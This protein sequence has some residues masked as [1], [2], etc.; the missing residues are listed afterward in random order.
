MLYIF[1]EVTSPH[2]W[3][4]FY[5]IYFL[6]GDLPSQMILACLLCYILSRVVASPL[7]W[8]LGFLLCYLFFV[9]TS[10]LWIGLWIVVYVIYFL[11]GDLPS[12]IVFGLSFTVGCIFS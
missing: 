4:V 6:S 9:V 5:V 3:L 8:S 7:K 10:R 2:L 12:E 11:C 1:L